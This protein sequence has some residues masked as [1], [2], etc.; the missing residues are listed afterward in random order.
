MEWLTNAGVGLDYDKLRLDR[1]DQVRI[2]VGAR[3]RDT[4]AGQLGGLIDGAEQIGSSSV[5]G[6]LAKPII[7]LAVSF[8]AE[9]DFA[10]ISATLEAN[11]WIYRGDSGEHGGHVFVLETQ[12][13]HRVAHLHVVDSGGR[14]WRDYLLLRDLLHRSPDARSRYESVK[15]Q[16]SDDVGDDRTAYT[17]GK[18][19]IV[20][21]LLGELG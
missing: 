2:D 6:L 17:D 12:P 8:A 13:W 14:Q 4:V 5:L 3:L 19:V 20:A 15:R 9:H 16:L 1:T 7:D 18:S 21:T 10:V 11:S